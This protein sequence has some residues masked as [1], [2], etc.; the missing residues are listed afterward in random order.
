MRHVC[1]DAPEEPRHRIDLGDML[2]LGDPHD[3]DEARA[4]W[5]AIAN[6]D[7]VTPSLR[8]QAYRKLALL[9]SDDAERTVL[10]D[11]AVKLP[12]DG[13]DRRQLDA[14]AYALHYTGPAAS[15][16]RAYFFTMLP[17]PTPLE[18]AAKAVTDEPELGF[19]HYILGLQRMNI[20]D[21]AAAAAELDTALAHELPGPAFVRFAARQ[22]AITAYRA[23]DVARVQRAIAVMRGP[24]MFETDRLLADDW[25]HRL[26]FDA[27]GHL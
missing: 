26:A 19:A 18:L 21:Y 15:D 5:S 22:L 4:I 27:T 9:A 11:K 14:A 6:D 7:H 24:D 17:K 12:L 16:L 10:I 25:A 8:G 1:A 23:N 13:D 20:G 3:R 2:S